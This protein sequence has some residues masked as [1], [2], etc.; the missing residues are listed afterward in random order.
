[1][2]FDLSKVLLCSSLSDFPI[3]LLNESL[4]S[5]MSSLVC[6]GFDNGLDDSSFSSLSNDPGLRTS[7]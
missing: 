2:G 5:E 6:C 3:I 1:M 4:E 7:S